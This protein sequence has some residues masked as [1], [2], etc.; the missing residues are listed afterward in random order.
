MITTTLSNNYYGKTNKK[1]ELW[2]QTIYNSMIACSTLLSK[3]KTLPLLTHIPYV[4]T[5]LTFSLIMLVNILLFL[6]Y[7][8]Q[9]LRNHFSKYTFVLVG[10]FLGRNYLCS[11]VLLLF[12]FA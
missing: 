1:F 11:S 12:C 6:Q 8:Q 3:K 10:V 2:I 7:I 5:H 4:A 9:K